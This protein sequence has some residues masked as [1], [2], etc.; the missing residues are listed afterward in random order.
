[1]KLLKNIK[2][3]KG[4]QKTEFIIAASLTAVL[5]VSFPAY[6]WFSYSRNLETLTKIKEPGGIIIRA[7]KSDASA[8]DADPIVNFEMK[9]IDIEDIADGKSAQYVFSV[10]TGEYNSKYHLLLAH[11]TNIPFSY[12]IYQASNTTNPEQEDCIAYHPKDD[13]GK[14]TY[15]KKDSIINLLPLNYDNGQY[16]RAIAKKKDVY[17]DS[18]Y[19]NG[20]NPEIYAVPV[21]LQ[22]KD[23]QKHS[24]SAA[25]S[26]DYYI[27]EIKWDSNAAGNEAFEK[28]NTAINNKETDIIYITA[29]NDLG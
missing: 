25:D 18:T 10:K 6:A 20:D 23:S 14:I 12:S 4:R 28:W 24:E 8:K 15:Y 2:N 9:E 16:G 27:L 29:F 11:T 19:E 13:T 22:T 26:Y 7:G 21:Y 17:Y 3:L 5:L 1:M